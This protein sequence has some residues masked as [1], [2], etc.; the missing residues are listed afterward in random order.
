M[1]AKIKYVGGREMGSLWKY[2]WTD[3]PA[4]QLCMRSSELAGRCERSGRVGFVF[5]AHC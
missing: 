1:T 4:K 2:F 3:T 5:Q